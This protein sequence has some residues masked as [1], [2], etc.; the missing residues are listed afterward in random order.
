[1]LCDFTQ[2]DERDSEGRATFRCKN[3]G[4]HV[5]RCKSVAEKIVRKC[6]LNSAVKQLTMVEMAE[7]AA[8]AALAFTRSGGKTVSAEV[9]QERN[10]HCLGCIHRDEALNRC[11]A[12]GCF[13]YLKTWMPAEKCPLDPPKWTAHTNTCTLNSRP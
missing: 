8:R 11:K 6:D 1:M 2:I 10:A 4:A 13:L 3:C 5:Y 9:H 12:C 7:A